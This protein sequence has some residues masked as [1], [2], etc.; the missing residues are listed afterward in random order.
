MEN[1]APSDDQEPTYMDL[2]DDKAADDEAEVAARDGGEVFPTIPIG[3]ASAPAKQPRLRLRQL[4]EDEFDKAAAAVTRVVAELASKIADVDDWTTGEGYIAAIPSPLREALQP[5]SEFIGRCSGIYDASFFFVGNASDG[6]TDPILK[7]LKVYIYPKVEYA[8][9][10]V[11]PLDSQLEG[12]ERA[13]VRGLPRLPDCSHHGIFFSPT[14]SGGLGLLSLV[15]LHKALQV[16]HAWQMLHSKDPDIRSIARAQVGQV[17]RKR[18]KLNEGHWRGRDDEITQLFLNTELAA[19][20]YATQR[21]RTGDISSLWTDVRQTLVTIGLKLQPGDDDSAPGLLQLR[22][23]HH[24]KWLSHKTVLRHVK[25]H[26]KLRRLAKWKTKM[27]QG[28]SV[29]E[30]G[31]VGSRFTTAGAGLSNGEY[32][33]A[34]AARVALIDTRNSL[35]NR[36]L[37]ANET[38]PVPGCTFA[39]TTAHVL[40][41]CEPNMAAVRQRHDDALEQIAAPLRHKVEKSGGKLEVAINRPVPEYAGAALR[42]DIVLRNTETKRAVIVDLAITHEDQ[43]ADAATSSALQACRDHKITKYQM[44]AAAMQRAGWTVRVA[45]IVYGS[46][47]YVL[48]SNFKVYTELLVLLKR[49]ARRLDR[50][51]SSHCIRASARIWSQHCA[52]HRIRQRSRNSSRAPR[53]SRGTSRRSSRAA[54]R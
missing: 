30:Q 52:Q 19:S 48:P 29:R 39:E 53:R 16:A 25:L 23:P 17:A 32:R 44:V 45:G 28:R 47:G 35:K 6:A 3:P 10:H 20:P 1:T 40:N 4:P 24:T 5:F 18:F 42:P 31:G 43:P 21:R 14:S 46:L 2:L 50:K 9:R 12:F 51:L 7:A 27:V 36:K 11:R 8:L 13:I 54:T 15:E 22:V 49:D 41:H 26:M 34:I 37:R 33:F 38:C